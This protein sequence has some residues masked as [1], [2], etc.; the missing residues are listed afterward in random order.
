MAQ[1][2]KCPKSV[3]CLKTVK[4]KNLLN[5]KKSIKCKKIVAV[6]VKNLLNAKNMLGICK[7]SR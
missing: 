7:K 4:C 3:E 1:L 5:E 6:Y 2:R